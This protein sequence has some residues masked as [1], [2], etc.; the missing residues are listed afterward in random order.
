VDEPLPPTPISPILALQEIPPLPPNPP[1]ILPSV[2]EHLSTQIGLD[3]LTLLDLRSIDPPPALGA[4]LLMIIGTARSVKHLNV[5]ADRFCRWAR[6]EYK[7][8]PYADGLLGRNELKLKLRRKARKMKL[9]QSV[10]NTMA[11]RDAD[12]GIT[13]GWICVNMGPVDEAVV[14]AEDDEG[15]LEATAVTAEDEG[16]AG[17]EDVFEDEEDEYMNPPNDY[18]GFGSRTNA[19]R[20]VVQ[21]FTE[22]K[23]LEMDLEGLW[24]ARNTRRARKAHRA[25]AAAES[26]VKMMKE[27]EGQD[28]EVD[29]REKEVHEDATP[30]EKPT[31]P[32]DDED[33][34]SKMEKEVEDAEERERTDE[35]RPMGSIGAS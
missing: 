27:E 30:V 23:R 1:L 9:A 14:P 18:V 24:D 8:R 4:N 29:E 25:N 2:L 10:G 35:S 15:G 17:S 19:P 5:S 31:D 33:V 34:P 6:K 16:Q 32:K 22:Q 20:I 11:M 3:N 13:T 7:L 12:D 21:M 28:E 26:A